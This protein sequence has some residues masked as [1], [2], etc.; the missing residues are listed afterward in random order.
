MQDQLAAWLLTPIGK[1]AAN[2]AGSGAHIFPLHG[3]ISGKCTCGKYP[4]GKDNKN[5]GKHPF[6]AHGLKDASADIGVVA[7]MFMYRSDLNIA[8]RTG[9]ISDFFV[10]D[11]DE[12]K[13]GKESLVELEREYGDL[14]PTLTNITGNGYHLI[15]NYPKDQTITNSVSKMLGEGLDIRGEGG[16]IVAPP[17]NHISGHVYEFDASAPLMPAG[18]PQWLLDKLKPKKAATVPL[19]YEPIVSSQREWDIPDVE[20]MLSFLNPSCGY[21]EWLSIG[22]ALHRGG[23]PLSLWD[24]WSQK[25]D[26]YVNGDCV[27]RWVGF[28]P[29]GEVTMGTL[30]DMAKLQGWKKEISEREPK[31]IS[32]V[33]PMLENIKAITQ[34]KH[35]RYAIGFD[36][37]K[38]PGL[39]GDTVRWIDE[40]AIHN[41]PVLALLN[42]IAFAGAV[43]G[44][45]YSSPYNTRTNIYIVGTGTTGSGKDF[46]RKC[47]TQLSMA[48]GLGDVVGANSIISASGLLQSLMARSSQIMMLDEFGLLLQGITNGQAPHY[49]RAIIKTLLGLYS[50]S[51]SVYN[52]GN[53][54]DAKMEPIIITSPNLCLYGTT[55][56]E[57]YAASLR[58]SAIES[59][60]LNRFIVLP[61]SKVNSY[62]RRDIPSFGINDSL[63]KKW[64]EFSPKN[65]GN[66]A[67]IVN[68]HNFLPKTTTVEWGDCED[69][70]YIIN[71]KQTD[72]INENTPTR[73]LWG[74]L[75]ENTIKIA[76]IFAIARDR[77]K[78]VMEKSDF[79]YAQS[80]VECSIHYLSDMA[81]NSMAETPH[82]EIH[83]QIVRAIREGG[84]HGLSKTEL[85]RRFRKIRKRDLDDLLTGMMEQ[86]VITTG[87]SA[88]GAVG[89]KKA[90][91]LLCA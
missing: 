43:F 18:A 41:Q 87:S 78:P 70:Q 2:Y 60:E 27:K 16:Y 55:T 13:G 82:E 85:L 37:L 48:A 71:C 52:H 54:A 38:I 59:G 86:E 64:E 10:L 65:S 46:S 40:Y 9:E 30:I 45:K 12:N 67:Q 4:C 58:K 61:G 33:L 21:D 76:M 72:R 74:R 57:A 50:D 15:F 42:T 91:Y 36:P 23:Y 51:N 19:P 20:K 26:K 77:E 79:D 73:H 89:R 14:P 53:Y 6:T 3:I 80:M 83:H 34:P 90:I 35:S 62:P 25:S 84:I 11:V 56:E 47:I 7:K 68:G 88:D 75:F 63:V 1:M 66:V 5:S 29:N 49:L 8:I 39:I 81:N 17:S 69:L 31:D 22:M 32:N 28:N 24:G 44:R